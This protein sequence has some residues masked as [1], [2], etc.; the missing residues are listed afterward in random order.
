M[1]DLFA[2]S[3]EQGLVLCLVTLGIVISFRIA[4]FPDLTVDGSF[5]TGASVAAVGLVAGLPPLLAVG[6]AAV[7]GAAAGTATGILHTKLGISKI[8]AGIL[9]M[10]MLYSVNLRI[11]GRSNVPLLDVRT[12]LTPLENVNWAHSAAF[13]IA[14]GVLALAARGV[15]DW[16]FSTDLGLALRAVGD[17]ERMAVAAGV[18]PDSAKILA[19]AMANCLVGLSG[20]LFAQTVGFADVGMGI[21][22]II[23]GFASL[24]IGEAVFGRRSIA[25]LTAAAVTGTI[26]YQLIV[27][28]ALRLGLAPTDLRLATGLMVVAALGLSRRAAQ[29][30]AGAEAGTAA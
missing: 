9:M 10:I 25:R 4:D 24:L 27:G 15:L 8:L 2:T 30:R 3:A 6:I 14:F 21:G 16:F 29:R 28:T 7:A 19:L 17:N 12:A 1:V 26:I 18:N 13:I 11:M 20:A 22:M 5:A 23:I